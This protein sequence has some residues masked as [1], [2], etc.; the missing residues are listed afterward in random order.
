M[1]IQD[2]LIDHADI[3]WSAALQEWNWLL[4]PVFRVWLL[5]RAGDLF[6]TT[7]DGSIQ[8]LEVGVGELRH[9]AESRDE[10]CRKIDDPS[11]ADDWLMIPVIDALK[12]DGV[13]LGGEQCY[14]FRVLPSL[15]G[16]YSAKN[17]M[18]FPIHEHFG[19]WGSV[20]RQISDLP[21]GSQIVI[22]PSE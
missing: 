11:V 10:F 12:A 5:T 2:Y 21:D 7:P 8:M 9:V 3:D 17:R 20:H 1:N 18:A 4:P 6:I 22:K 19:G 15:G 14:S 16:D 13:T